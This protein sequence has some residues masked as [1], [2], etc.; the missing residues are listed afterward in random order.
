MLKVTM[1]LDDLT[2][3]LDF[4][5]KEGRRYDG[6]T[7][8]RGL[9]VR[10]RRMKLRALIWEPTLRLG[11]DLRKEYPTIIDQPTRDAVKTTSPAHSSRGIGFAVG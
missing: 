5:G 8:K 9:V 4:G 10:I 11:T 7:P 3:S 1:K 6:E 2:M